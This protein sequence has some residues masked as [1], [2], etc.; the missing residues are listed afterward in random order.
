ML[1]V[2]VRIVC[3]SVGKAFYGE[4][5]LLGRKNGREITALTVRIM[6]RLLAVSIVPFTLVICFGPWYS[7]LSLAPKWASIGNLCPLSVPASHLQVCLQPYKRRHIPMWFEQQKLLFLLEVSRIVI[8]TLC[9]VISYFCS[10]SVANT[11]VSYSLALTVQYILSI[12]L[13][14]H[15]L[16]KMS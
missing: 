2:P 4:I 9:L 16:R 12:I 8:V 1:S 7:E 11:I 3:I 14:F 13:L 5:A 15:I 10:L 6:I